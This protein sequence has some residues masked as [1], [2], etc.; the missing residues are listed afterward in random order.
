MKPLLTSALV[1]TLASITSAQA[2]DLSHFGGAAPGTTTWRVDAGATGAGQLY[3]IVLAGSE[4]SNEILPGVFLDVSL[5]NLN[6]TFSLP[7]FFGVLDG[8][9]EANANL[10]LPGPAL[11]GLLIS[12]QALVGPNFDAP[13]NLLRTTLALPGTFTSTLSAP[14]LPIVGG[15]AVDSGKRDVLFAG[16]SGVIPQLYRADLEEFEAAGLTF[17]VGLL[18][19]STALSDGRV[20][21]TGGLDLAGAPTDGA[22]IWDPVSGLT[23]TLVMGSKR[24][25]H[26]ASLMNNGQVLISGGFENVT[27]DLAAILADPLQ[28]LTIFGGV[29]NSTELFDP[30]TESFTAGPNMLEAR[31][32]HSSTTTSSGKVLVAGG[33]SVIPII[34]LPTV[35]ATAY[36]YDPNLGIFG[37][38]TLF[39]GGR[40]LHSAIAQNDGS[41][42][43][44]GGLTL[45]LTEFIATGD[46]T[47]LVVGSRDDILRYTSGLFGGSFA[48]VGTMSEV[49]AGAGVAL[50]A[51]G[52]VLI[53]GGLKLSLSASL[54]GLEFALLS[55]SDT[56]QQGSGVT[57]SA[58]MSEARL[59]PVL[60][61]LD[62]GTILV[63][64]GGGLT[65]EV[66]QP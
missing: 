53:A 54:A 31:A 21:F 61:A 9:G 43:L 32:L 58:N 44:I 22:A 10:P 64:G 52:D 6:L 7:G 56:Y 23:T 63:I 55:S 38:P 18:A 15:I 49:R 35:S 33:L 1:L 34:G 8:A 17:G 19:Q 59:L 11:A 47:T 66:Y 65:A 41:V 2:P 12:S 42:L 50:A 25:G 4:S 46:I 13:S 29:L 62:D 40:L 27:I 60:K 16:G 48:T 36:A 24:A 5:A 3:G 37:F 20:L 39:S 51:N 28:L 14:I 26:G 30:V 45:D 57:S